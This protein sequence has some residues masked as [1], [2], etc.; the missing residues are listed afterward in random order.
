MEKKVFQGGTGGCELGGRRLHTNRNVA[1]IFWG[2]LRSMSH[3]VC[4][5]FVVDGV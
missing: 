5:I 4:I 1:Q 2:L 3:L